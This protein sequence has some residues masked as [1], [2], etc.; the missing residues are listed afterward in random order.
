VPEEVEW[1]IHQSRSIREENVRLRT[2]VAAEQA[3]LR[4]LVNLVSLIAVGF[5][6]PPPTY[7]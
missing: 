2:E 4:L 6:V 3:R 7:P 5:E 1:L